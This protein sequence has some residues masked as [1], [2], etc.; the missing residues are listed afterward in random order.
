MARRLLPSSKVMKDAGRSWLGLRP[1]Q[2][3]RMW[4]KDNKDTSSHRV[5]LGFHQT[6]SMGSMASM[7]GNDM[8][9]DTWTCV[10]LSHDVWANSRG[11]PSFGAVCTICPLAMDC[12]RCGENRSKKHWHPS[13]W[14]HWSPSDP[15]GQFKYCKICEAGPVL[16]PGLQ[17]RA[18]K[19]D[20]WAREDSQ[21][22]WRKSQQTFADSSGTSWSYICKGL[23][24]GFCWKEQRGRVDQRWRFTSWRFFCRRFSA[25][26][27]SRTSRSSTCST[28]VR[29]L[30]RK[31]EEGQWEPWPHLL[32]MSSQVCGVSDMDSLLTPLSPDTQH[33]LSRLLYMELCNPL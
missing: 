30:I 15:S 21:E 14:T 7:G 17:S 11:G 32:P 19:P 27:A 23:S 4:N 26:S 28:W 24:W 16:Q 10:P 6:W 29:A 9:G 25:F 18:D 2:Q 5:T 12:P 22:T 13:Q 8:Q 33:W 3:M 31:F 1:K 20:V